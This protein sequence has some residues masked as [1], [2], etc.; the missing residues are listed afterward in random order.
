MPR[1]RLAVPLALVTLALAP[2]A[3]AQTLLT[4]HNASE[5]SLGG[6]RI[7]WV[8]ARGRQE[9]LRAGAVRGSAPRTLFRV[10]P[11]AG[12]KAYAG[13]WNVEASPTHL[14]FMASVGSEGSVPSAD[15]ET[16]GGLFAGPIGGP[17]TKLS[18]FPGF[19]KGRCRE[20]RTEPGE[21]EVE[22]DL[23]VYSEIVTRCAGTA[24]RMTTRL[25]LRRR[26]GRGA[27]RVL[28]R[29]RTIAHEFAPIND[30]LRIAGE[31]L[32]WEPG[33]SSCEP[34]RVRV[35]R[36][37]T[38]RAVFRVRRFLEPWDIDA[39]GTLVG[40]PFEIDF[41]RNR[42]YDDDGYL[43]S[44]APSR[45][46]P[47]LLGRVGTYVNAL[48]IDGERMLVQYTPEL[49]AEPND[50]LASMSLAARGRHVLAR[51]L[52][53]AYPWIEFERGRVAWVE[54]DPPTLVYTRLAR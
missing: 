29:C 53:E 25:V 41:N 5:P 47:R 31:F 2:P 18:G 9:I 24:P 28:R 35:L 49:A 50:V 36:W 22:H 42:E 23:V 45:P 43:Y 8:E 15:R 30:E 12:P 33:N 48:E 16:F 37:R 6:D 32:A 40:Q 13:I 4:R 34:E 1:P 14:A 54:G 44:Y 20:G 46:K 21:L 10:T 19:A 3:S 7:F 27:A 51:G 52:Q 26:G 17:Y 11:P 38:G 39:R